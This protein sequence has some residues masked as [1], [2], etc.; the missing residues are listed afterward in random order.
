MLPQTS[1]HTGFTAV[2]MREIYKSFYHGLTATGMTMRKN[3]NPFIMVSHIR[4]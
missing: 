4:V 1:S 2:G 3:T